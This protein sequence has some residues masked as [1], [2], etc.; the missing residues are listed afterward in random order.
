MAESVYKLLIFMKRRP[1]MSLTEFR[2]YY[3]NRH[4]PLCMTYMR[5]VECYRR[6]YLEPATD[7]A[8]MDFDVI[9]ELGFAE[10]RTRDVV[11][12]TLARDAMPADV[13]ADE[14]NVFER[15]KTRAFAITECETTV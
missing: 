2:D 3:E 12:D 11:L 15:A 5:G 4:I 7:G 8:E 10:A 13:I 1:G 14:M 9:T 6:R